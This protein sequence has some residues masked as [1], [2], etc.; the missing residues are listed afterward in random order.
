M[1]ANDPMRDGQALRTRTG[2]YFSPCESTCPCPPPLSYRRLSSRAGSACRLRKGHHRRTMS[3]P[4]LRA[5]WTALGRS[6]SGG[7]VPRRR[8]HRFSCRG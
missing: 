6:G 8:G 5:H 2:S 1:A 3:H 7:S 4:A